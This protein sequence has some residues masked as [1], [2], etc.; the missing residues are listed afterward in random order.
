MRPATARRCTTAL[1]EPPIAPLVM[2]A[3]SNAFFVRIFDILRSSW[4]MSTIRRPA[5]RA[6]TRRRESTAGIAALVGRP[7]PSDSTIDAIVDAVPIVMQWPAERDMHDS[8]STMSS[9]FISPVFS[10]SVNFHTCVPEPMSSPRYLPFSIGPPETPIVG[11]STEAAPI[12]SDGVVLS[13]PMSSTTPSNGLARMH[14]STSIA[15]WLRNSIVVGRISVSPRLIT[16]NSIGKPPASST[17]RRTWSASSRK[18]A[19]HGVASDHVL[20]MPITGRPSNWS[21]G[22]PWFFIHERWTSPSRS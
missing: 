20:Q 10:I 8:T 3:F 9:S 2:I 5:I 1:V 11:R 21:W 7:M 16:G 12:S 17:P 22:T 19:L 18:C 14:S 13:Q 15:A 6:S 4:T